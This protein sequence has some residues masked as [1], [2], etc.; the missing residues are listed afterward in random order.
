M[1]AYLMLIGERV[2]IFM[3]LIVAF[4]GASRI[5]LELSDRDLR[6]LLKRLQQCNEIRDQALAAAQISRPI[7]R[8]R[9]QESKH[10]LDRVH[11]CESYLKWIGN[12]SSKEN[13]S[14]VSAKSLA[15]IHYG[16]FAVPGSSQDPILQNTFQPSNMNQLDNPIN[17]FYTIGEPSPTDFSDQ[18]LPQFQADG[19]EDVLLQSFKPIVNPS[20]PKRRKFSKN[21]EQIAQPVEGKRSLQKNANVNQNPIIKLQP[22][23]YQAH[24]HP[25]SIQVVS[26]AATK[27]RKNKP[28]MKQ[29]AQFSPLYLSSVVKRR[30]VNLTALIKPGEVLLEKKGRNSKPNLS[31]VSVDEIESLLKRLKP[32]AINERERPEL[33][34]PEIEE[35]RDSEQD[36]E[37]V[38]ED[39]IDELR[40]QNKLDRVLP[41]SHLFGGSVGVVN[42]SIFSE[43]RDSRLKVNEPK[44]NSRQSNEDLLFMK[45]LVELGSKLGLGSESE[46]SVR[47]VDSD[48]FDLQAGIGRSAGERPKHGEQKLTQSIPIEV[49][50]DHLMSSS[51]LATFGIQHG[52]IAGSRLRG[53]AEEEGR[54]AGRNEEEEDDEDDEED[55]EEGDKDNNNTLPREAQMDTS[56]SRLIE[57]KIFPGNDLTFS[58]ILNRTDSWIPLDSISIKSKPIANSDREQDSLVSKRTRKKRRRRSKR[59]RKRRKGLHLVVGDKMLSRTDMIRLIRILNKMA[60]KREPSKERDASRKLL[61]FLVKLVLEEFNKNKQS[62]KLAETRAESEKERGRKDTIRQDQARELLGSILMGPV[63]SNSKPGDIN[64]SSIHL[65]DMDL[66]KDAEKDLDS[67]KP[68][69]SLNKLS[70]DLEQYF[71]SDFFEDMAD[72][73]DNQTDTVQ[74]YP[75]SPKRRRSSRLS[76]TLPVP[77]YGQNQLEAADEEDVDLD[78]VRLPPA[79]VPSKATKRTAKKVLIKK[80]KPKRRQPSKA[81]RTRRRRQRVPSEREGDDPDEEPDEEEEQGRAVGGEPKQ[82]KRRTLPRE[83]ETEADEEAEPG[84]GE[85]EEKGQ[86]EEAAEQP[87]PGERTEPKEREGTV[88]DSGSRSPEHGAKKAKVTS[89]RRRRLRKGKQAKGSKE[90]DL[91]SRYEIPAPIEAGRINIDLKRINST[92]KTPPKAKVKT[93]PKAKRLNARIKTNELH[94]QRAEDAEQ[95]AQVKS[96]TK[97]SRKNRSTSK[98]KRKALAPDEPA[99]EP[100]REPG[101]EEDD[102]DYYNEG[103]SYSEVC[104]D[105]GKCQVTVQSSSPKLSKAIE[106]RDKPAIVKHL[107]KSMT[108]P[109]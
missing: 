101:R 24:E 15:Q 40:R 61:K 60:N 105:D 23:L 41:T 6:K 88:P 95:T 53:N 58:S 37:L 50:V 79:K 42:G 49:L 64:K 72:K 4:V 97:S 90:I 18:N 65:D 7:D 26:N 80:V 66:R 47:P 67:N 31:S 62:G 17:S 5:G 39:D 70:D 68:S 81:K 93:P 36:D 14:V 3:V 98:R 107:G 57:S 73:L 46:D 78:H 54:G 1:S 52:D 108:D 82:V 29:N 11:D 8:M 13:D 86:A 43:S 12:E 56:E 44:R 103:T 89:G 109:D 74:L 100:E 99:S 92:V 55:A 28:K 75:A 94:S 45:G 85:Q 63:E 77:I 51:R 9:L 104:D 34:K 16:R 91:D 27:F 83:E 84:E 87:E 33:E 25:K 32:L 10:D 76:Y 69:V 21:L 59:G 48:S 96:E 38:D 35:E 30:P 19:M 102:S 71:D 106:A 22:N 2:L 20:E